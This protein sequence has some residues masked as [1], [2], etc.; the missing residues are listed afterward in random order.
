MKIVNKKYNLG[1]K[2]NKKIVLISDIHYHSKNDIKRLNNVLDNI[3]KINPSYVC[4]SGDI[5]DKANVLDFD[6]LLQ[7]LKKLSSIAKVIMTLGNHEFYVNKSKNIY[8]LSEKHIN[9]IKKIEDLYL[10]NNE[11][12]IID[13]INFIG[14]VLPIK[15]Y[16]VNNEN[17]E[18]FKNY[19]ENIKTDNKYYNI[20]LCHSPVNISKKEILSKTDIDLVLCGHMHGGIVPRFLRFLFGTKGLISPQKK[21]FPKN[22]YGNIKVGNKNVIITSG[23]KVLSESHCFFLKNIFSSEIVEINL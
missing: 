6:L 13:N 5:L 16:I 15:H 11:N 22:V 12:K 14:L 7:W 8:K 19:I 9:K 20:L 18:E 1:N 23:I 3:K 21:L 17:E 10:L 2:L 4:I